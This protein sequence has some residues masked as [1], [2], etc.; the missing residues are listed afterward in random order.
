VGAFSIN[1]KYETDLTVE[2]TPRLIELKKVRGMSTVCK[3]P[4]RRE[5]WQAW[6]DTQE[7]K[8][9][10]LY[11]PGDPFKAINWKVTSRNLSGAVSGLW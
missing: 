2:V 8:E 10:R 5:L 9:L 7:F 4:M 1:R 11:S 6:N 3:V